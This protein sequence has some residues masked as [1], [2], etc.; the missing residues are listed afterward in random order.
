MNRLACRVALLALLSWSLACEA[1]PSKQPDA[2]VA[3][4][5]L[6]WPV[7][8]GWKHETFALPPEFAPEF[9]Y[10]GTEDL[11]F[12]PGWSSPTAPD[13]W[14]Y[15]FVWSLDERPQFDATSMAAALT[16]YFR[17]LSTAVGGAR[18]QFDASRYRADLTAVP[19]S[20]PPRLAGRVFTYDAFQ[21]GLPLALNVEA[22]L[23]SC[24]ETGQFAV[25][26]ALSPKDTTDNVWKDLRATAAALTWSPL[27]IYPTL[28]RLRVGDRIHYTV[29]SR[30]DGEPKFVDGY[31]L[32][33]QDPAVVRVVDSVRLEAMSPGR[34]E[35]VVRSDVGERVLSIEVEPPARPP[36]A[37]TPLVDVHRLAAPE[38][39][40]VGHAN[41]DG[42]DL[43]AV[44]KPGID[45]L[46]RE[47]KARGHPVVYFVSE[48]YPFWYTDD[49]Q[50][51]LAVVSEGQEHQ[52][53]VDAERVVFSGGDFMVCT[54]RNVQMTLHGMLEAGHRKQ[55]EFVFPADALFTGFGEPQTYPAPMALLDQRL[56]EWSSGREQYEHVVVPFL[57]RL[58][59]EFPTGGYP[60]VAPEPPL[61]ELVEGWTVEVAIDDSFVQTW[62][63]GNPDQLIRLDFLSSSER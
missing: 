55:I 27:E 16:T 12:M 2:A 38:V 28:S 1:P 52:I 25:V 58:F 33:S 42:W 6:Q 8:A 10:R 35:V 57:D 36:I 39:L 20:A 30:Q 19:G 48:D 53:V 24:P 23:R 62:R 51:D 54:L 18:Y 26:V 21:T 7:P 14:S 49:R 4:P 32:E 37:A 17:G 50:P 61:A 60:A 9:P 34:A 43:T 5:T 3:E 15:D 59:G 45:R 31:S 47:F 11:R 56:S 29:M 44:A 46:V 13:F 63:S 41:Q 40:F 22:E